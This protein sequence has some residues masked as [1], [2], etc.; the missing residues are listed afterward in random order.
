MFTEYDKVNSQ[1]ACGA[2]GHSDQTEHT[3]LTDLRFY[4]NTQSFAPCSGNVTTWEYC[5]YQPN[6]TAVKYWASFGIYRLIGSDYR[7]VSDRFRIIIQ[8]DDIGSNSLT[9][10]TFTTPVTAII[11]GDVV[12]ACVH[13]VI[14]GI[15][16]GSRAQINLAGDNAPG[17]SIQFA[18]TSNGRCQTGVDVS[19][20]NRVSEADLSSRSSTVLHLYTNIGKY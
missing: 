8:D 6:V 17:N 2:V 7:L 4:L 20:P 1:D 5:Y 3:R 15:L 19:V 14:T 12:G 9:C 18:D 10:R 11:E 16:G 13:D